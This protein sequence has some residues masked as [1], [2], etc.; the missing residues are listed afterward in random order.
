MRLIASNS[1]SPIVSAAI[2]ISRMSPI[3]PK[4]F[5]SCSTRWSRSLA[6]VVSW[7]SCPSSQAMRYWRP[8][9]VT[10]TCVM[11][12]PRS[13]RGSNRSPRRGAARY[14][15]WWPRACA[16]VRSRCRARRQ[17]W[18]DRF[19]APAP[20]RRAHLRCGR[21]RDDAPPQPPMHRVPLPAAAWQPRSRSPQSLPPRRAPC[22]LSGARHEFREAPTICRG[23]LNVG[24]T[25]ASTLANHAGKTMSPPCLGAGERVEDSGVLRFAATKRPVFLRDLDEVDEHVLRPHAGLFPK[26]FGDAAKQRLLLLQAACVRDGELDD[27]QVV[28]AFDAEI[29]R[30]IEEFV[31]VVLGNDHEAVVLRDVEGLAHCRID[32]LENGLAICGRFAAPKRDAGERHGRSPVGLVKSCGG[33]YHNNLQLRLI[34]VIT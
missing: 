18:N 1:S 7:A 27:H 5:F 13:P 26:L 22:R 6:S 2:T 30:A 23:K 31:L 21:P 14:R 24:R 17:A 33:M 4:F 34:T 25:A 12:A 19:Q 15:G 29:V 8:L 20:A 9:M 10:L 28:A 11:A 3:A 16:N 32:A